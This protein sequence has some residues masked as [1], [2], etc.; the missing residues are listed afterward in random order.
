MNSSVH[1]PNLECVSEMSDM[2]VS[3]F[4]EEDTK[5]IEGQT[6]SPHF[7][8]QLREVNFDPLSVQSLLA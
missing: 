6:L 2:N 5:Q 3:D 1:P 4:P 7:L 8:S